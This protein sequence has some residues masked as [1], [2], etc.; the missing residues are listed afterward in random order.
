MSEHHL[1]M[2]SRKYFFSFFASMNLLLFFLSE[3]ILISTCEFF[4]LLSIILSSLPLLLRRGSERLIVV[5]VSCPLVWNH[6]LVLCWKIIWGS[7][8]C[9]RLDLVQYTSNFCG[10][11][12][13]TFKVTFT[14][15]FGFVL[16]N[17]YYNDFLV[18][19]WRWTKQF[20]WEHLKSSDSNF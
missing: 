2:G 3:I 4:F 9:L 12:N 7:R 5:E 1:L 20:K 17:T 15:L 16:K 19:T 18:F 8:F 10:L 13:V 6:Q 14:S 11:F